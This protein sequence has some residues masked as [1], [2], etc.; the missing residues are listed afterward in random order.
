M[1]STSGDVALD[2]ER[3]PETIRG[4]SV[5]GDCEI[6]VPAGEGFHLSYRTVSGSFSTDVPLCGRLEKKC[7]DVVCGDSVCGDI[8]LSSVS[9]DISISVS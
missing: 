5:S 1:T 4:K 3:L 2:M 8:S 9:G 6:T 7:G